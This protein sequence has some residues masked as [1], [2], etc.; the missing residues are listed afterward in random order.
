MLWS[1]V[2][3]LW[4]GHFRGIL[5]HTMQHGGYSWFEKDFSSWPL[6]TWFSIFLLAHRRLGSFT[7]LMSMKNLDKAWSAD[8]CAHV[9]HCVSHCHQR[10]WTAVRTWA[11]HVPTG[12]SIAL[13]CTYVVPSV[14]ADAGTLGTTTEQCTY[15]KVLASLLCQVGSACAPPERLAPVMVSRKREW[16]GSGNGNGSDLWILLCVNLVGWSHLLLENAAP[17]ECRRGVA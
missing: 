1:L 12:Q 13:Q 11:L 2:W 14:W 6:E 15:W 5:F 7:V 3:L 17:Q 16:S 8:S 10:I 9:S 4:S